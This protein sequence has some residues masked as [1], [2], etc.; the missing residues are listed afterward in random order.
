MGIVMD[1][2]NNEWYPAWDSG[3]PDRFERVS[4]EVWAPDA[5][6]KG[7]G[8]KAPVLGLEDALPRWLE[9]LATW[10]P[11][12]HEVT[13]S[14]E[15]GDKAAWMYTWHATHARPIV[16]GG[17]EI[18]ATGREFWNEAVGIAYADGNGQLK[19]LCGASNFHTIL[20]ELEGIALEPIY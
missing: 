13:H 19:H 11:Q 12:V 6:F 17:R 14:V 18:P 4:R 16:R 1:R 20:F 10:N 7:P 8:V 9:E 2:I 5:T 3:D 15:E